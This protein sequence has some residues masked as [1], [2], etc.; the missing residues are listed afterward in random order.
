MAVPLAR[1]KAAAYSSAQ[2]KK[3]IN[4]M[5]KVEGG[6]LISQRNPVGKAS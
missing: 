3:T 5:S 2:A 6:K 4:M 1:I